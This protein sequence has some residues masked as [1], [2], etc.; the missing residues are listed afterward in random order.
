[1]G[2]WRYANSQLEFIFQ[3]QEILK[4]KTFL[5]TDFVPMLTHPMND[6]LCSILM[7]DQE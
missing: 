3:L 6:I 4:Q 2:P 5:Q 1:M 7:Q